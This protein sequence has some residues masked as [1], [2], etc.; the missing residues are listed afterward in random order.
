MSASLGRTAATEFRNIAQTSRAAGRSVATQLEDSADDIF[1]QASQE[2]KKAGRTAKAD[3]RSFLT[4]ARKD[5]LPQAR[6]EIFNWPAFKDDIAMC[7]I[8]SVLLILIPGHQIFSVPLVFALGGGL[9]GVFG[10]I[11]GMAGRKAPYQSYLAKPIMDALRGKTRQSQQFHTGR[12]TSAL[13]LDISAI[14]KRPE[15]AGR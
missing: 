14:P 15:T 5:G 8:L 2:G 11:N 6:K 9:R 3:T 13:S 4:R 7:G 12:D 1:V 10:F